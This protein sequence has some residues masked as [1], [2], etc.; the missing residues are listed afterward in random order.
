[1]NAAAPVSRTRDSH[2]ALL[3]VLSALALALAWFVSQRA[4]L[5]DRLLAGL[6]Q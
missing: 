6:I 2:L 1:M 4:P 3:V 5:P